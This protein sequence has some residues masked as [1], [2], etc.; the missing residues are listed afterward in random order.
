MNI[1]F[2]VFS[3]QVI[4]IE[5]AMTISSLSSFRLADMYLTLNQSN[6][7]IKWHRFV[8]SCASF[9]VTE[10]I[11]GMHMLSKVLLVILF[12]FIY[13]TFVAILLRLVENAV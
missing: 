10:F 13:L 5:F 4:L 12:L 8:C 3:F 11:F 1:L 9:T 6:G 7:R 2:F